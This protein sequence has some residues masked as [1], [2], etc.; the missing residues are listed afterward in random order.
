M[1]RCCGGF[2]SARNVGRPRLRP[3]KCPQSL[4]CALTHQGLEP[5]ADRIRVTPGATDGSRLSQEGLIDV[6]RLLHAI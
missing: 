2:P 3:A 6:K 5:K 4:I 1:L